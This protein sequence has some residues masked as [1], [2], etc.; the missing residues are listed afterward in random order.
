MTKSP[1]IMF[2]YDQAEEQDF[3]FDKKQAKNMRCHAKRNEVAG[4]CLLQKAE[5]CERLG[6]QDNR[7]NFSTEAANEYVK[8][9]EKT[10]KAGIVACDGEKKE[11][12]RNRGKKKVLE[13]HS[14]RVLQQTLEG[15]ARRLISAEEART[16]DKIHGG[17]GL[18]YIATEYGGPDNEVVTINMED[19]E[20]LKNIAKSTSA[21]YEKLERQE[22]VRRMLKGVI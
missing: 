10:C 5:E 22:R 4:D 12:N 3:K 8:S 9:I 16:I 17:K 2:E 19:T 1:I 15:K 11:Y 14:V 18:A 6:D 7:D 21:N 20:R 13:T